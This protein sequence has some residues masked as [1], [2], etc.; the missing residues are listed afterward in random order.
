VEVFLMFHNSKCAR[1]VVGS[2]LSAAVL[3]VSA[4]K[5]DAATSPTPVPV[6]LAPA[7]QSNAQVGAAGSTLPQPV[8]VLVT[9]GSGNPFPGYSVTWTVVG[10]GGQVSLTTD[11]V[12]APSVTATTD[13]SGIAWAQWKLGPQPGTDSLSA[14]ILLGISSTFTAT[15]QPSP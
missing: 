3:L 1:G 4:C 15:A 6:A 7:N 14:S 5:K 9:D 11:T 13:A 8:G 2:L 10:G 12:F